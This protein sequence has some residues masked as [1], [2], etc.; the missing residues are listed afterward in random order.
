KD[1][2]HVLPYIHYT[3]KIQTLFSIQNAAKNLFLSATIFLP[4][5]LSHNESFQLSP[6][7]F[8]NYRHTALCRLIKHTDHF[9]NICTLLCSDQQRSHSQTCLDEI[10]VQI[11]MPVPNLHKLILF[12]IDLPFFLAID[13]QWKDTGSLAGSE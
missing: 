2:P 10:L 12:V 4:F 3:G 7:S 11:Q 6:I 9:L 8:I 13:F 5:F 1:V